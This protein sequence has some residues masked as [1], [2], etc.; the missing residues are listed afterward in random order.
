MRIFLITIML[1]YLIPTILQAQRITKDIEALSSKIISQIKGTGIEKKSVAIL[2]FQALTKEA[3][4]NQINKLVSDLLTTDFEKSGKFVIIDRKNQ[5]NILK[6]IELSMTGLVDDKKL[7]QAGKLIAAD[8][9]ITGS[10][11]ELKNSYIITVKATEVETAKIISSAKKEVIKKDM[12]NYSTVLF[13]ERKYPITAAFRSALI[14]GWGL[15]YNERPTRGTIYLTASIAFLSTA[16]I[17]HSKGDGYY[18]DYKDYASWDI[19]DVEN[20]RELAVDYYDKAHDYH[21]FGNIALYSF[22]GVWVINVV[23]AYF[24]AR[25][26]NKSVE[27][28]NKELTETACININTYYARNSIK[29]GLSIRY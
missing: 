22:I 3:E 14:P 8:V 28:A 19:E 26:I 25:S 24:T 7:I 18:D 5:G 15:F 16:V 1:T 21:K 4:E 29:C 20:N 11:S 12:N 17:L 13:T 6:E 9:F 2:E 27:K 23:D 10:V